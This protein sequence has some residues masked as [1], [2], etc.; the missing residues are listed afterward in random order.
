MSAVNI[1][2]VKY[3]T[4]PTPL[5]TS[6]DSSYF[7][8]IFMCFVDAAHGVSVL[9]LIKVRPYTIRRRHYRNLLFQLYLKCRAKGF[10]RQPKPVAK[11]RGVDNKA[12]CARGLEGIIIG[13]RAL[14]M[15]LLP[16]AFEG[17]NRAP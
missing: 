6:S 9:I 1:T 4:F 3:K 13:F 7:L 5:Q 17:R 15:I 12:P 14:Q 11:W 8:C 10:I 16:Q 2:Q